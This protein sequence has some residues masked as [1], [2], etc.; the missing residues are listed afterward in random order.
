[1]KYLTITLFFGLLFLSSCSE[2]LSYEE[3]VISKELNDLQED[4]L[5]NESFVIIPEDLNVQALFVSSIPEMNMVPKAVLSSFRVFF[6][7]QKIVKV[8]LDKSIPG[9]RYYNY[10]LTLDNNL[11]V[12]FFE[13]GYP[14][15]KATKESNIGPNELMLDQLTWWQNLRVYRS[16]NDE[17]IEELTRKSENVEVDFKNKQRLTINSY[18]DVIS[19][20]IDDLDD[21]IG[22]DLK[23]IDP[24]TLPQT[25]LDYITENYASETITSAE[26]DTQG[27]E[28]TLSNGIQLEFDLLGVFIEVSGEDETNGED[29]N[30]SDLPMSIQ[31]YITTNYPSETITEAELYTDKYEVSLSNGVQLEF[32]LAGNFIE[33][34]GGNNNGDEG[35]EIAPANLPQAIQDYI[36]SNYPMETITKAEEYADKYEVE[37]SNGL[38]LEFDIAGNFIEISGNE[39]DGEGDSEDINPS[40][41]PQVILDYIAT[42]YPNQT[43]VEAEQDSEK[44]EVEL[45]NGLKLEFDLAG[46]FLEVSGEENED[47]SNEIATSNLPQSIRDYVAN[48]YPNESIVKAEEYTD[49]YEIELSNGIELEFDLAGNFIEISGNEGDG[50]GDSEDIN[51]SSLPQVILDYIATNYP[52]ETIVEAEKDDEKYE[53][54]L[55]NGLKL[56]FDL[57][58]NF[59]EVSGEE[60]EGESSE[61]DPLTLPQ[62][63]LDYVSINYPNESIV[64]AEEY[65]N[66]FEIELSN[67]IE[68]EFD[69]S[70]NFLEISGNSGDGEGSSQDIDPALLPQAIL[71]YIA[72]NYPNEVIVE[73]EKDDEKYEVTLT[74]NIEL[75][76]DLM[77]NFLDDSSD[78][79]DIMASEL[80]E[81]IINYIT[82]N[83]PSESIEEAESCE[84]EFKVKLSN[85]VEIKFDLNGNVIEISGE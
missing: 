59:L 22:F 2:D 69:L 30:P 55:S 8:T 38:Q 70:G 50:E 15:S 24:S 85:D 31:D 12:L 46:N 62:A 43:I 60:N 16:Y 4:I 47:G 20:A 23:T 28:V 74:N 77:G 65:P 73:A 26:E 79:S 10:I 27:Y 51:P 57:A 42:N 66:K 45:S 68:L 6:P 25:I 78:C 64:K 52:N 21:D 9:E 14:L 29:I 56:E 3:E 33:A 63:I 40:S 1:M 37:L 82:L 19:R 53:V 71:D 80:P 5:K 49:K 18:G 76:F 84:M 67:G 54:E 36:A 35:T 32:D 48:N 44:Y 58:G 41:L 11:E 61:I 7:E 34:S 72:T 75:E 13:N 81:S 83:Y 39:G 17:I